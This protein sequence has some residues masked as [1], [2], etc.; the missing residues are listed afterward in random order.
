MNENKVKLWKNLKTRKSSKLQSDVRLKMVYAT[1]ICL[2]DF[3]HSKV[4]VNMYHI[5]KASQMSLN[6]VLCHPT[7]RQID[8]NDDQKQEI[9]YLVDVLTK[10][11]YATATDLP[12]AAVCQ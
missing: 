1:D 3:Q 9:K 10:M 4:F 8:G 6:D 2:P 7:Q 5:Q 12:A 11:S